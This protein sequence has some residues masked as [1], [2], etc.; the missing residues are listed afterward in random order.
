MT[1]PLPPGAALAARLCQIHALQDELTSSPSSHDVL[2][3]TLATATSLDLSMEDDSPPL[4]LIIVGPPGSDKTQTVLP[5]RGASNTEF[6]DT[7]T[8]HA[9]VTAYVNDATGKAAEDLL[10]KLNGKCLLIKDLTTLFSLREDS[11]KKILGDLQSIYDGAYAKATG[12]RGVVRHNS[13][14]TIVGCVTPMTLHRH[15]RYMSTIGGRFLNYRGGEL[16]EEET[17]EGFDLVLKT[18]DRK[19]KIEQLQHLVVEHMEDILTSPL[20]RST[21]SKEHQDML[22]R[23]AQLL[24]QGRTVIRS[25]KVGG[26]YEPVDSQTEY[27]FRALHQLRT[28]GRGLARVHGRPAVTE[29]EL[30]LVRRVVL[31]SIPA[32][33]ASILAQFCNHPEGFT[34]KACAEGI[35]KSVQWTSQLLKE[36][37]TCRLIAKGPRT[38]TGTL[39]HPAPDFLDLI[40]PPI[41][42]LD[43][44]LNLASGALSK[45]PQRGMPSTS[46][47]KRGDSGEFCLIL[48]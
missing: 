39:Y 1:T 18:Q 43:H 11:V 5:L 21:E 45:T 30:E 16:T 25:E 17:Q 48:Q 14:F 6:L 7:L 19:S 15:H 3:L 36:L 4:W 10:P 32:D 27:P 37:E 33:G 12:T 2:E 34:V 47:K 24:A 35:R 26:A 9:F 40:V 22:R 46:D 28:L 29:H 42:P 41:T 38:F 31:S 44:A 23:L 8:D 20:Q 13:R